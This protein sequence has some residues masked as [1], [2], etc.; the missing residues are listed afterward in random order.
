MNEGSQGKI[1]T[2]RGNKTKLKQILNLKKKKGTEKTE[3]GK[4]IYPAVLQTVIASCCLMS[5]RCNRHTMKIEEGGKSK[6]Q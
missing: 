2:W 4:G 6:H 3:E 1:M 5:H